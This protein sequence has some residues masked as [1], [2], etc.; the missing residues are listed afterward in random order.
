VD[1][2]NRN[3]T[4]DEHKGVVGAETEQQAREAYLAHYEP[5]WQGLRAITP[6]PWAEF[7]QWVHDGKKT[8]PANP[9]AFAAGRARG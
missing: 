6:M 1:Q 2:A 3:G 5:G 7:K 8:E 9:A 4:F